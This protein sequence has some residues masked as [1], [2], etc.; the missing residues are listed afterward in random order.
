MRL[1]IV[2]L[3]LAILKSTVSAMYTHDPHSFAQPDSAVIRH[4]KL[5]LT[6]DFSQKILRGNAV[7]GYERLKGN[8]LVLDTRDLIIETVTD[9]EN[10]RAL[11]FRMDQPVPF[12]GQALHIDLPAENHPVRIAYSTTPQAAALQWLNP[13]QTAGGRQ[14]FL[15]SQ[16]QAILARTWAPVQDSP[17]IR[18]TYDATLHVPPGLMAVMSAENPE[19]RAADGVYHFSMPQAIPA[20]LLSIAV[21]DF[22]FK[23]IDS[24]CGVYAEPV[25]MEKA[26]Y[27]FADMPKMISAA[28]NLYGPYAW[29]RYDLIV[30]PPSFPFGGMENPRITFATPTIIAGDRSLTSLV[31]HELAHSW[32][33]NLVT[34]ATW[35]DFWLNEGFTVYFENRIMESLYGKDFADMQRLLGQNDLLESVKDMGVDNADT[36]L[37]LS[38]EG[39][40]PDDGVTDIA[41]EK[42]NNLLLVIEAHVGRERWD[43]F[44]EHYFQGHAFRTMDTEGFLQELRQQLFAQDQQGWDALM[45]DKWVYSTGL[46]ENYVRIHSA[47]FEKIDTTAALWKQGVEISPSQTS[48]WSPFEWVRFLQ[49]LPSN[50]ETTRLKKLAETFMLST[51]GNNEIKFQWMMLRLRNQDESVFPLVSK[52]L[53]EVGR[54]KYVKP[55]FEELVSWPAGRKQAEVIFNQ[56]KDNYHAITRQT[57]IDILEKQ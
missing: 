11:S 1:A 44:L 35:N 40:D 12:L 49:Q 32:S 26:A 45:I 31:A 55:L 25:L 53:N 20:Y 17:G 54:R 5:E 13:K 3:A 33:G 6:V 23:P 14:P 48:A 4:V 41:Y 2:T 39:R 7:I 47:R 15:F 29:G 21:G 37:K 28:E 16:S 22:D 56:S 34:N 18:F 51:T 46:P 57:V 38:L 19:R 27:E 10:G 9:A 52:F 42:G 24:R 8:E 50:A 36:R 43:R 30:L